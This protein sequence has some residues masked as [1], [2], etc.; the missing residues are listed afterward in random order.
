MAH[1]TRP[2]AAGAVSIL[3]SRVHGATIQDAITLNK[4]VGDP[5]GDCSLL[6]EL[7]VEEGMASETHRLWGRA[8]ER[9]AEEPLALHGLPPRGVPPQAETRVMQC[10]GRQ[11]AQAKPCL[12]AGQMD[13]A[14]RSAARAV[15]E[16][17]RPAITGPLQKSLCLPGFVC[18]F[19]LLDFFA[20]FVWPIFAS[21]A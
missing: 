1:Q 6:E 7:Q 15:F 5:E 17:R 10:D 2:E 13:I 20:K 14:D 21:E 3:L 8:R 4:M 11:V 16:P 9:L 19:F 18:S 12:V